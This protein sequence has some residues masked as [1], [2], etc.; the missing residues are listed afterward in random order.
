[1][2]KYWSLAGDYQDLVFGLSSNFPVNDSCGITIVFPSYYTVGLN[3]RHVY[4][5]YCTINGFNTQCVAQLPRSLRL[6]A[7]PQPL[8]SNSSF[9]IRVSGIPAPSMSYAAEN[10]WIQINQDNSESVSTISNAG[11]LLDSS[12]LNVTNPVGLHITWYAVG[13]SLTRSATQYSW[14]FYTNSSNVIDTN[15][16][17]HVIFP[18]SW[19]VALGQSQPLPTCTLS[20]YTFSTVYYSSS[21]AVTSALNGNMIAL[22]ITNPIP[23][24]AIV[25]LICSGLK[26]PDFDGTYFSQDVQLRIVDAN[27]SNIY[28]HSAAH[29]NN[30]NYNFAFA[31]STALLY[32]DW[33]TNGQRMDQVASYLRAPYMVTRGTYSAQVTLNINGRSGR[34]FTI[35]PTSSVFAF[36]PTINV[37]TG[38][39][40]TKALL[41]CASSVQM[42]YYV[43][44]FTTSDTTL[45]TPPGSIGVNINNVKVQFMITPALNQAVTTLYSSTSTT[46]T[47]PVIF[48]SSLVLPFSDVTI[49]PTFPIGNTN[50]SV[51][52]ASIQ[53]TPNSPINWFVYYTTNTIQ[54]N[55]LTPVT[56][57]LSGT[58]APAYIVPS[59]QNI[60]VVADT[61]ALAGVTPTLTV[62]ADASDQ[63]KATTKILTFTLGGVNTANVFWTVAVTTLAL[64]DTNSLMT[65]GTAAQFAQI[66]WNILSA[67]QTQYFVTY[68][69][70]SPKN[71]STVTV[72]N[73]LPNV[74]YD[75]KGFANSV[76]NL[77]STIA[78]YSF[79]TGGNG[80]QILRWI[81]NYT[82]YPTQAQRQ[83]LICTIVQTLQVP[84]YN[85]R[86]ING[87]LCGVNSLYYAGQ[88]ATGDLALYFYPLQVELDTIMTNLPTLLNTTTTLQN[89]NTTITTSSGN[90]FTNIIP[91]G[92][93]RNILLTPSFPSSATPGNT[94]LTLS[95]VALND[96]GFIIAALDVASGSPPFPTTL[97]SGSLSNTT[98]LQLQVFW[99]SPV[100]TGPLTIN[101]AGLANNTAYNIYLIGSNNDPSLIRNFTAPTTIAGRTNNFNNTFTN[102]QAL[103][104]L[105]MVAILA[106]ISLFMI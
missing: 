68:Q 6:T 3:H 15:K 85:V 23:V 72:P 29:I 81:Y 78:A 61:N 45:Y 94:S 50:F 20:D 98:I 18:E 103:M 40:S 101:F 5:I 99:F 22:N 52:P 49:T 73:L 39:T 9:V 11:T 28:Y 41:G 97:I 1:L 38:L 12:T 95:N 96:T 57:A 42:N 88:N 92:F 4:G 83:N 13:S 69:T 46:K 43:V 27:G 54:S 34:V 89:I 26:T 25:S 53:L 2:T 59:T 60:Q 80:A 79:T 37:T 55:G 82:T 62:T 65:L 33:S 30:V 104:S 91:D 7:F 105:I 76:S 63:G 48:D 64:G 87:E 16:S 71:P 93:V 77:N 14:Y 66:P 47:Q 36:W 19:N 35:T 51:S 21:P 31:R 67:A 102:A 90:G 24:G 86:S 44:S 10:W 56:Y 84:I 106:A 74:V 70:A 75:V 58:N 100:A 32:V 8:G 17:L